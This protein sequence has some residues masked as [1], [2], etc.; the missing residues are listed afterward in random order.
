M[1]ADFLRA[2][3]AVPFRANVDPVALSQRQVGSP[4]R[5][6]Q[7]VITHLGIR[8]AAQRRQDVEAVLALGLA[9]LPPR[10][11]RHGGEQIDVADQ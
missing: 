2:K 10:D 6:D 7:Q 3:T 8:L 11:R 1:F 4:K 9:K 5:R